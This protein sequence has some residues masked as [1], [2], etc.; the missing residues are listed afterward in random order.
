MIDPTNMQPI[1]PGENLLADTRNYPWHRPPE[2][3]N[4]DAFLEYTYRT[5]KRPHTLGG[6]EALVSSGVSITTMT[7]M[8]ISRSIMDG[9]ITIDFGIVLA[10][11]VAKALELMC[12]QLGIDYEM[13]FEDTVEI[14]TKA[15]I[16]QAIEMA[17]AAGIG[18]EDEDDLLLDEEPEEET[19]EDDLGLMAPEAD[20]LGDEADADTQAEMLG[21]VEETED[22]LQ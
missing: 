15:Y 7:D 18:A 3:D 8:F 14:P 5:F 19:V 1:I 10:G 22:E 4:P 16:D 21:Q 6:L 13:G 11:P 2:Y 17:E 20:L 12:V 9:L